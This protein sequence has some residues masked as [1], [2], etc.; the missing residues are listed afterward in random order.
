MCSGTAVLAPHE[1]PAQWREDRAG[2]ALTTFPS[3]RPG[4]EGVLEGRSLGEHLRLGETLLP[5]AEKGARG[6]RG[7]AGGP[8]E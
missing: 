3:S 6:S 8:R 5:A 4:V 1:A 2:A 7:T